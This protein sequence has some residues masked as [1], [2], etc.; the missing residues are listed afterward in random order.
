MPSRRIGT[1][2][3]ETN[4]PEELESAKGADSRQHAARDVGSSAGVPAVRASLQKRRAIELHFE[5]VGHTYRHGKLHRVFEEHITRPLLKSGLQLLGLFEQGK[6]N[7]LDLVVRTVP[8]YFDDLA[9][10]F[11]GFRILHLSDFHIDGT[12]GLAEALAECIRPL[13]PDLCVLTG[14]YRFEDRG[15]CQ[16]VYPRMRTVLDS[17]DARE[18][19]LGILGNHDPADAVSELE[20]MG[21]RMLVNEAMEVRRGRASIWIAGLDDNFDYQTHDLEQALEGVPRNAFTILLAHAPELF[22]EAAAGGVRLY[23]AGHTHGGQ[24]RL[25][26][27]GAVK[28]NA[29]C[30]RQ[31]SYGHWRH[32][33]MQGYTSG[34]VGCSSLPIRFNCPPELVMIELHR[35]P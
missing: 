15:P 4:L 16:E 9:P 12:D 30:P 26:G 34:G 21:V 35:A 23:L 13:R 28:H 7:A 27:L 25:P 32:E 31:Y 24:I 1:A 8:M 3:S 17:I 5:R 18:G 2:V 20:A 22:D 19:V 33:G 10:E 11:H 6:R 29:K 14:D